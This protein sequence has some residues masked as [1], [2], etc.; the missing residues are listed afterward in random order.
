MPVTLFF[1]DAPFGRF[2]DAASKFKVNGELLL[3]GGAR[4]DTAGNVSWF[5]MEIISVRWLER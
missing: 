4:T 3:T 2:S 5:I 1:L